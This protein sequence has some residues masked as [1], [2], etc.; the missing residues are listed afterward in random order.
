MWLTVGEGANC[1]IR[2]ENK[3]VQK[4]YNLKKQNNIM[5]R[6][7]YTAAIALRRSETNACFIKVEAAC[8]CISSPQLRF[9]PVGNQSSVK[10]KYT[11]FKFVTSG[12]GSE[13]KV[14]RIS[15]MNKLGFIA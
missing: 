11:V 13:N 15:R 2:W 7:L 14:W 9:F 6:F 4:L 12:C 8:T 10:S 5:N 1:F 3:K